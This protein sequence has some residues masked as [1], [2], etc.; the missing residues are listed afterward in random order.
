[1]IETQKLT[2]AEINS[3]IKKLFIKVKTIPKKHS[4]EYIRKRVE[5]L[6]LMKETISG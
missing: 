4:V 5:V 2:E 1:M 6:K 3:E